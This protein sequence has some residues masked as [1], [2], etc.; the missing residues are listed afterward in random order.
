MIYFFKRKKGTINSITIPDF[1]WKQKKKDSGMLQWTNPEET[2]VLSMNFFDSKPDLPSL[3]QI[4]TLR[5][6][7]REQ[8]VEH[9]GGLIQVDL[10][11]CKNHQI[12]KTIFKIPLKTSGVVYLASLTIPFRY[13]SYVIKIQ[14]T[15]HGITGL[16]D[17]VIADRLL[18]TGEITSTENGYENWSSDPYHSTFNEGTLMNK[19]EDVKYDADFKKHPLTQARKLLSQIE[20]DIQFN[21]EIEKLK[22]L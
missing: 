15:E 18:G 1:G 20:K 7:Y 16:R 11:T 19:S 4:N 3:K 9:D 13:S 5:H 22:K 2:I 10:D 6:F 8:I 17:S 12:I 14:A 21:P